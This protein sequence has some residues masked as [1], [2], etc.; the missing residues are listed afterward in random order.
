[1]MMTA[2][3]TTAALVQL[4]IQIGR[5]LNEVNPAT[6]PD[7]A[8]ALLRQRRYVRNALE[9]RKAASNN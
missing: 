6:D 3:M 1:M 2:T 4:D 9:A 5:K 8:R 7:E